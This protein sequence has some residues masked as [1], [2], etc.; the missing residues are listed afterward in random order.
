MLAGFVALYA[1]VLLA[2]ALALAAGGHAA[3]DALFES[4]SALGTVGLSTGITSPDLAP[5][6]KL[7]L[8]FEM[9][10]GRLEILPVLLVCYPRTWMRGRRVP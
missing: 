5:W 6:A 2:G 8:A 9:W 1:G 3:I 10:A 4:A 7:V